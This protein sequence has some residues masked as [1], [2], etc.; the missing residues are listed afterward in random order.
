MPKRKRQLAFPGAPSLN[1]KSGYF[2]VS[3]FFN[4]FFDPNT[5]CYCTRT[6]F[7]ILHCYLYCDFLYPH[8][9]FIVIVHVNQ[10]KPYTRPTV[11]SFRP[12]LLGKKYQAM[13]YI[14]GKTKH[15][16]STYDTAV[17]AAVVVDRE[18]IKLRRPFNKLNFPDKAPDGYTPLQ[19]VLLS[20]N[21]SGYRG[22]Y[23]KSERCSAKCSLVIIVRIVYFNVF[24]RVI[25][26][27]QAQ[28][29]HT[30]KL[31]CSRLCHL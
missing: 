31:K 19:Q 10:H 30:K 23:F 17:E 2:G 26:F 28:T 22:K 9:S 25:P 3:K 24:Y 20:C 12:A 8:F 4:L 6:N 7:Y 14:N 21:N 27:K 15:L 13:I 18:A 5:S 1:S 11:L 29:V 16:G